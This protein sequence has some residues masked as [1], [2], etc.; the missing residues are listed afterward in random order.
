MPV[1]GHK[2]ALVKIS[3][4]FFGRV[5]PKTILHFSR[6]CVDEL[7]SINSHESNNHSRRFG[8]VGL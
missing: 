5:C 6:E 4:M 1:L 3:C 2:S 8:N 7:L